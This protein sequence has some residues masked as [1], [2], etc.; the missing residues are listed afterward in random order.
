MK[1]SLKIGF[2]VYYDNLVVG[3]VPLG[4]GICLIEM[5]ADKTWPKRHRTLRSILSMLG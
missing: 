2:I 4:K 1:A 3:C 5:Q